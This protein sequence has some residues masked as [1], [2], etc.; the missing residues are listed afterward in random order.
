MAAERTRPTVSSRSE[1]SSL[2]TGERTYTEE[3]VATI[4]RRAAELERERGTTPG[5]LSL[6]EIEAIAREAGIDLARVREAAREIDARADQGPGSVLAGAPIRRSVERIVEGE[7]GAEHHERLAEEIG[8]VLPAVG[9]GTR[10]GLSGGASSVGRTLAVSGWTGTSSVEV[11]VAPREGKTV[12]RIRSDRGQLAGGLFG[13]IVGGVGGG[14]GAN[15]GWMLPFFL[16][17]PPEV[18]VLGAG[19]VVAGAYGL[20]RA[21]F[22]RTARGLDRRLDALADRLE[23]LAQEATG[24]AGGGQTSG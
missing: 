21:I 18:G 17:L 1:P 7:L 13:G 5:A 8:A 2:S 10:W 16:H 6:P 14:L 23:A 12:I 19:V 15:V 22:G 20:A 4:F 24:A 9:M 3:Q 11:T